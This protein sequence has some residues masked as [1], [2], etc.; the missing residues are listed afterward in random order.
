MGIETTYV[1]PFARICRMICVGADV[2]VDERPA[3]YSMRGLII[4]SQVSGA[5]TLKFH[6]ILVANKPISDSFG[7]ND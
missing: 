3:A 7:V 1:D 6:H 4:A 2:P 5:C